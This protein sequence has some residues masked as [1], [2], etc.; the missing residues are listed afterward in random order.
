VPT[1]NRLAAETSPYLRQHADNPVDWYPWGEEAFAKAAAE[2]KPIFLSVGYSACH[3]CHVMAHESFEDAAVAERLNGAFVSIKVDREERPDVDAVYM[4]AVQAITGS[5]GWPMSVFLT[6]DGRPFYGGTYFPPTDL[7]GRPSFTTVLAA[8]TDIWDDRRDEVEEQADEL[9]QAI[10]RRSVIETQPGARSLLDGLDAGGPPD[11]LTPAVEELEARFDPEWGGF[12]GAPKFPQPTLVDLALRQSA[13]LG[14]GPGAERA[15][16]LATRTLDAMAAGGIHDHLGGGFARYATDAEWLVPHFEKMLYD[17]AGLLRAYLH[18]WQVTGDPAYL[19]VAEGIVDYVTRDLTSPE[20]GVYSAEDADSEGV[21]G[22]FYVWS[23][24]QVEG[25]VGDPDVAAAVMGWFGI[26][27]A[28]NF[29]GA[30]ILRRPVGAP[31]AGS[32]SVEDGRRRLLADRATRVRPGLDDKVLTEW[33][34]MYASALAEAAAATGRTDWATAA[35]GI[36]EFLWSHLRDPDGRWLRSWQRDGGARHLA[37]AAD[38]AWVVDCCTRLAELTGRAVW[39]ERAAATADSLVARF[40]DVE[41][42]GF[43]TT[44]VDAEQ[45]IVRTKDVFDGATPS[46]NAV[47][48]LA[49]AR[50]GA[51]TGDGTYT[52]LARGVVDLLGDLLIRHPTAFAHTVLTADFLAQGPTEVLVTGDRPDLLAEVRS[53][54]LP[55]AVLAWGEPTGS[56]LWDGR[57][58]GFAYVCRDYA[59]R[60]PA[61]DAAVLG[62]QLAELSAR[63]GR[64]GAC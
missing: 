48:A 31:L 45:L 20:G 40:A 24:D 1:A 5:G 30:T 28:G 54:W 11:L 16:V 15:T 55:D 8:L 38:H 12:G 41:G 29:E 18:G 25:A 3:W 36:G 10:A 37:Y 44:A 43:F 14:S 39:I 21:E 7:Q 49:L 2:D 64:A 42:G 35:V 32:P 6:P 59:C 22:R 61:A 52:A 13:R 34:A 4:E 26:T 57:E 50:L 47:A 56:P 19:G 53:R 17:Q 60:V 58:P 23:P 63:G 62:T 46:A 33:N 27:P 51:L 9:A